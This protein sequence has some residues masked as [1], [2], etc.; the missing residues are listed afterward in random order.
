[1]TVIEIKLHCNGWKVLEAPGVKP[2]FL[3]KDHAIN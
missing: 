1:M 3:E 2:V